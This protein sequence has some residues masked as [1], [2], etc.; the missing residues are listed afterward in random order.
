MTTPTIITAKDHPRFAGG[1]D[2]EPA[3]KR[4]DTGAARERIETSRASKQP[5]QDKPPT[6][7]KVTKDDAAPAPQYVAGMFKVPIA[8][9]YS[10]VGG[11]VTYVAYPVGQAIVQ[12]A[13]PCAEAWDHVAKQNP[14]VRKWLMS[15]TKTGAWGELF[16]AHL[17]IFMACVFA[18]GS[19]EVRNRLGYAVADSI[20]R[21]TDSDADHTVQDPN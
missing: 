14:R 9:L 4:V 1:G 20:N 7:R 11:V 10:Q 16:A 19:D 5:P 18:F 12:Q 6:R 3:T 2:A 13:A 15:M 21:M 8:M 17:P